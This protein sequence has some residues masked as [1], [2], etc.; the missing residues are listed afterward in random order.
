MIQLVL[1]EHKLNIQAH[2]APESSNSSEAK[3]C[4]NRQDNLSTRSQEGQG[5]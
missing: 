1:M 4:K 3:N 2:D 5:V